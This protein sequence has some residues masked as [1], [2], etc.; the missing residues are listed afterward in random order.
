[1]P[2]QKLMVLAACAGLFALGP[3]PARAEGGNFGAGIILGSPTGLSFKYWVREREAVDAAVAASLFGS[4]GFR[5]HADYLW[6]VAVLSRDTTYD[7]GLYAGAGGR[8]LHHE[9]GKEH[10]P[11]LHLGARGSVG[12]VFDFSKGGLPLDVFV[13]AAP[14]LDFRFN[15][16]SREADGHGNLG[17]E[18]DLGLGVRYFF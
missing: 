6:V 16:D 17:A 4:H 2:R 7:L 18:L 14:I 15:D 5:A 1:M 9:R 13:E 12:I 11:D 8:V 10:D 3:T